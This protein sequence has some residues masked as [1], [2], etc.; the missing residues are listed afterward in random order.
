MVN[1]TAPM[2]SNDP[3]IHRL[4]RFHP[5]SSDDIHVLE[6]L[7][8]VPR[9]RLRARTEFL[10]EGDRPGQ[11]S[12]LHEGWAC[13]LV[14]RPDGRRQIAGFLLPGDLLWRPAGDVR[15]DYSVQALT[16]VSI[17]P[18]GAAAFEFQFAAR[19]A[20]AT[21]L[22]VRDRVEEAIQRRWLVNL[23]QRSALE[24]IG[25]L[26][27]ELHHRLDAIGLVDGTGFAFP[28]TQVE[29]GEATGL[30]PVHV[31]RTLRALRHQGLIDL[32]SRTL[33]LPQPAELA[34]RTLFDPGYLEP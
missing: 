34:Q 11:V 28:V 3:L 1:M 23:G 15:L 16:E 20:L 8:A 17:I 18:I 10:S 31:N 32:E 24:R 19:P 21:A 27:C 30:T 14:M 29:L 12:I 25:H 4:Q 7:C 2:L 5:L 22:A 9:R 26:F 33:R 6:R 13:K